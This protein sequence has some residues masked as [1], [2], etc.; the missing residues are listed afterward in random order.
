MTL[1]LI[2][3]LSYFSKSYILFHLTIKQTHLEM[4]LKSFYTSQSYANDEQ[5][6]ASILEWNWQM[7][8]N[9]S[10]ACFG[11]DFGHHGIVVRAWK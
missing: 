7:K 4:M 8:E 1:E 5:T 10:T 9:T 3:Q 2:K 11:Y 6:R